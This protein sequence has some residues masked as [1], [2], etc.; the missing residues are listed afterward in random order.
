MG[1]L[2]ARY[3]RRN[4]WDGAQEG[5]LPWEKHFFFT[6]ARNEFG[7]S[8]R[9]LGYVVVLKAGESRTTRLAQM[10]RTSFP[11][12]VQSLRVFTNP[13]IEIAIHNHVGAEEGYNLACHSTSLTILEG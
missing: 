12:L 1:L 7:H 4:S 8:V 6:Q 10:Y 3:L 5:R 13:E 9:N 2:C 11:P